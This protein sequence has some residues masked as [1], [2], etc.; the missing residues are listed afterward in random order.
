MPVVRILR[1][2]VK[3]PAKSRLKWVP[4]EGHERGGNCRFD[5]WFCPIGLHPAAQSADPISSAGFPLASNRAIKSTGTWW[6]SLTLAEA[7]AAI[8]LIWPKIA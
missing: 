3:R 4:S 2:D 7:R 1:R 8:D 6:D 5:G